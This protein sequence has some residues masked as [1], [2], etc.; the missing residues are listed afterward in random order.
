MCSRKYSISDSNGHIQA[1]R[2]IRVMYLDHTAKIGGGEIA[3]LNLVKALDRSKYDPIFVLASEGPFVHMLQSQ[4]LEV[5]VV[6]L[7]SSINDRRKDTIDVSSVFNLKQILTFAKYI[8]RLRS[9]MRV[10]DVDLVHTNS[11]KSDIYGGF[12]GRLA[13]VPVIWHVHDSIDENYLPIRVARAFRW[14]ASVMPKYIVANSVSTLTKLHLKRTE[15]TAVVYCGIGLDGQVDCITGRTDNTAIVTMVGR[16]AEWKGQHVFLKAAAKVLRQQP[17]VRFQIVGA[18]LFGEHEYE[19]SLHELAAELD[20]QRSVEF[21]GFRDDVPDIISQCDLLVHSSIIAEPF[22]QVVI[23]G[24]AAGKP[25]IATNGGALPEI[26]V[27]GQTGILVKMDNDED[28]ATAIITLINDPGM[29]SRM[30]AAGRSRVEEIFTIEKSASELEKVYD[31]L[32]R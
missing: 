32:L 17:D 15:R 30:G 14:L 11:L 22:G 13:W 7:D 6:E 2:T 28:M 24:M 16:I 18:P 19:K 23:E 10:L 27:P 8:L 1:L 26:V 3:I 5:H 9:L 29:R 25:V 12:A 31:E 20:I 21:M 4:G